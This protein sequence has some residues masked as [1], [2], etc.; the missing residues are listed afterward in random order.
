MLNVYVREYSLNLSDILHYD[1]RLS[2]VYS[3]E[4]LAIDAE[5]R[6][7]FPTIPDFVS[8]SGSVTGLHSAS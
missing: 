7:R 2:L 8:S 6:V 4:F 1:E 5:V 3:S